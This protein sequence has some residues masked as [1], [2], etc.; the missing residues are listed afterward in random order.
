[1]MVPNYFYVIVGEGLA[2]LQLAL[3]LKRDL[4]FKGKQIAIIDHAP[5][6]YPDKTWCFWEEGN[7]NWDHLV[8]HEW[9]Q[10]KIYFFGSG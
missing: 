1:M 6:D 5:K 9:E 4:F 8:S 3:R 2:G 10:R 7:G